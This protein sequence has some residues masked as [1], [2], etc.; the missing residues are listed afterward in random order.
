MSKKDV[1]NM[2]R[3]GIKN[4]NKHDIAFKALDHVCKDA[5]SDLSDV[6][7][8]LSEV[9]DFLSAFGFAY[10]ISVQHVTDDEPAI[11]MISGSKPAVQHLVVT[12]ANTLEKFDI[13]SEIS[14]VKEDYV[15][16]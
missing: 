12:L 15:D 5:I 3:E 7:S 8:K 6:A 14:F 13:K 2:V 1:E 10:V 16:A 4:V 9:S 11:G